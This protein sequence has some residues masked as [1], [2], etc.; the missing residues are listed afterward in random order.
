MHIAPPMRNL[1]V[2]LFLLDIGHGQCAAEETSC[3][4][5]TKLICMGNILVSGPTRLSTSQEQRNIQHRDVL[6]KYYGS[7]QLTLTNMTRIREASRYQLCIF[8]TFS[9]REGGGMF[10]CCR[11]FLTVFWHKIDIKAF[12]GKIVQTLEL[13]LYD[14][15]DI[16][17]IDLRLILLIF[18]RRLNALFLRRSTKFAMKKVQNEGR[19]GG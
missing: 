8:L 14:I 19:G 9:K 12:Y 7:G 18:V 3:N 1:L 13:T 2:C 10:I 11:K 16:V 15:L 6:F 5:R 17:S 4:M